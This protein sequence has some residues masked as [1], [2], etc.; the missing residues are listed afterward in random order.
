MRQLNINTKKLQWITF[1]CMTGIVVL[2]ICVAIHHDLSHMSFPSVVNVVSGV[3]VMAGYCVLFLTCVMD[4][5]TSDTSTR[6][7]CCLLMVGFLGI[8][9]DN[10]GWIVDGKPNLI[11]INHITAVVSFLNS[12]VV[13]LLFWSYQNALYPDGRQGLKKIL[14]A[15]MTMD[16]LY[17]LTASM[18]GFLYTIDENG[19]YAANVG[20]VF[21]GIYPYIVLLLCVAENLQRKIPVR[22]RVALLAF[23]LTPLLAGI[24]AVI[25]S[26]WAII[27]VA[28]FFDLMLMYGVVQMEHSIAMAEQKEELAE[29]GK[30]L[31]V[32]NRI[33]AEQSRDLMEKQMQKAKVH[34]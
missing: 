18:T 23:N 16:I 33:M 24:A 3:L 34:N 32:Q 19:N 14:L 22:Q 11:W 28:L 27:Y 7:F 26:D 15:L 4:R 21:A 6:L 1:L 5:S 9:T 10:F 31:A 2:M 25:I 12:A 29:Q 13:G 30:M 8:L 17:I 20:Y